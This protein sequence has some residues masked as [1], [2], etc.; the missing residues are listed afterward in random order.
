MASGVAQDDWLQFQ[1]LSARQVVSTFLAACH[2]AA[3]SPPLR[4]RRDPVDS[5]QA[6]TRAALIP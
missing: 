5:C 2:L 6:S 3:I 4:V 1:D